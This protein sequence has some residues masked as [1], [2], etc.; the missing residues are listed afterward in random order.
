MRTASTSTLIVALATALALASTA[1]ASEAPA[2]HDD[3][4]VPPGIVAVAD[5]KA[6]FMKKCKKC[7][8]EDGKAQTKMGKKHK[9]PDMTTQTTTRDEVR[10]VVVEG[11]KDTKMKS[12]SK[13]LTAEE[14]DAVTDFVRSLRAS[15]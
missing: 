14:I 11:V 1:V 5:G 13:K 8:G 15:K 4:R 12:F 10:K 9:I 7:H 2:S 6:V 3:P